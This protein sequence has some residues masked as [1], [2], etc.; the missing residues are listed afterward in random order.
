MV[1]INKTIGALF[2]ENKTVSAIKIVDY[3]EWVSDSDLSSLNGQKLEKVLAMPPIQRGFI[4]KPYQIQELWDSLLRGMPIGSILVKPF[5]G[6]E[7]SAPI[8]PVNR[9][10]SEMGKSGFHLVD[11]QQRTLAMVLGFP[12]T[13]NPKHKLWVDFSESGKNGSKFQFRVTTETQPFGYQPNGRGRL[14]MHD[15][16]EARIY[17]DGEDDNK[18]KMSNK[19]IYSA[20][21]KPWKASGKNQNFLFEV[22]SLWQ[23]LLKICNHDINEW[24]KKVKEE[25]QKD[26][27]SVIDESVIYQF[28]NALNELQNQWLALIKI[29]DEKIKSDTELDHPSH[30]Y[31]TMLF[32][33]ISS[34]GTKLSPDD[35]LFSM[36]KQSWPEAHNLVYEINKTV[37]ALM[38]P[39]DFVMTAYRFASLC[40]GIADN[41]QPNAQS[42]HKNLGNLLGTLKEYM[43]DS[44]ENNSLITAFKGMK[45]ILIYDKGDDNG[46]PKAMFPYL[47]VPLQQVILYWLLD[48]KESQVDN[49]KKLI[50][51]ALFWMLCNQGA[52]SQY[53][54]SKKAIAIISKPYE[55]FPIAELY[56]ALTKT[57]S[58]ENKPSIFCRLFPPPSFKSDDLRTDKFRKPDE[59]AAYFFKENTQ[60]Y[61]NF[62][63]RRDLL[64]WLQRDWININ[65]VFADFDPLAGQDEDNVPYDFDHLVPQSNWSSF[66]TSGRPKF[67]KD[68]EA[69][70]DLWHRRRLGNSIGNYRV[71]SASDNRSRN[72]TSL[73]EELAVVEAK[74]TEPDAMD[75]AKDY[76]FK[77]EGYELDRW[78]EA[79]PKGNPWSLGN[80]N[81]VND[82]RVLAF[83]YAVESRVLYLYNRYYEEAGFKSWLPNGST[84]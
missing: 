72:D 41:P 66:S 31:L 67:S 58:D 65:K 74:K 11:G 52:K 73:A 82:K 63:D 60:L 36:V 20:S 35:L 57:D 47:D 80:E 18:K 24:V 81:G 22:K 10:V 5:E 7:P 39:T 15:R 14:S 26:S 37:G 2:P 70:N 42:F 34:N 75:Y 3:L 16:R 56:E 12:S 44:D 46:I 38:K 62:S 30:D 21:V 53:E 1:D 25:I 83:Q 69:F 61:K 51:F 13:T 29:P 17:W 4:W 84:Q 49:R 76:A 54:A 40:N 71:M 23:W 48:K 55:Q 27:D 28:G 78:K 50:C 19:E 68:N 45:D 33:R 59:R 6:N 43:S 32:D 9:K 8:N 77:P 64:I 79:S